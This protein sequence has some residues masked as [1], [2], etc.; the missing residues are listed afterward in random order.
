MCHWHERTE[1]TAIP[2]KI[3]KGGG[4]GTTMRKPAAT[5]QTKTFYHERRFV[6]KKWRRH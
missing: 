4:I 3:Q 2:N 6:G 5:S 1:R